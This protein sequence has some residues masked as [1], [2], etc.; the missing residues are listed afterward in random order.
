[1]NSLDLLQ[2]PVSTRS[3]GHAQR[4][5]PGAYV[6]QSDR[7]KKFA[8]DT[9]STVLHRAPPAIH[10]ISMGVLAPFPCRWKLVRRPPHLLREKKTKS[11]RCEEV[12]GFYSEAW[13]QLDHACPWTVYICDF[14]V[15]EGTWLF[16]QHMDFSDVS[17]RPMEWKYSSKGHWVGGCSNIALTTNVNSS[18]MQSISQML[19]LVFLF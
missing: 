3:A 14:H 2:K 12:A 6:S 17:C 8:A 11:H 13:Q 5:E 7:E 19:M 18:Q 15:R 1:M 9:G 10:H 4:E 16:S